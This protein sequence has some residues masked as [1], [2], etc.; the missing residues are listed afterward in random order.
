MAGVKLGAKFL[1]NPGGAGI[2]TTLIPGENAAG[3]PVVHQLSD[4]HL[5]LGVENA[6]TAHAGGTQAAALALSATA[7]FH[8]VSTCATAGDSVSLPTAVANDWHYIRND[9]AAA[10]Q[11][12]GA[13]T[14]TINGVATATGVS[15]PVGVGALFVSTAANTWTSAVLAIPT[16]I[17]ALVAYLATAQTFTKAQRGAFVA[18][19]DAATVALDLS[20]SNQYRLLLAGNRTLGVPTNIVEGQQGVIGIRQDT[21]GTRT[22]AYS[23]PY[24]W[25][26]GTAGV[27]S[28]PGCSRDQLV[29]SVENYAT[30]IIT[31]T[32]AT[33]GV[34]SWI[35]HGL[36]NGQRIQLTTTGA[37]P[38]GLTAS[39]TY[40]VSGAAT[41]SFNLST[42]LVNAAAGTK[43]AT[44]GAQSGVHTMVA[45]TIAL[46]LNKA[47]A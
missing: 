43:I 36:E 13:G 1:T 8:R 30:S 3:A 21:T 32:I 33:P 47:Y 41:D 7:K 4:L 6:L 40:F 12:F 16:D 34:V 20:L 17:S 25:T 27:L 10:C 5:A 15:L 45:A 24:M 2:G 31:V 18:L 39:T 42:T 37:L 9:G 14:D 35:A 44:S 38:T 26:G 22:L 29:Y 28:T 19:T 23:W 11:V 46:A